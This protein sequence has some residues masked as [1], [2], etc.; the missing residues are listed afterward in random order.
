MLAGLLNLLPNIKWERL[1]HCSLIVLSPDVIYVNSRCSHVSGNHGW[2]CL[3]VLQVFVGGQA[4][5]YWFYRTLKETSMDQI[6]IDSIK[7]YHV[8]YKMLAEFGG[9]SQPWSFVGFIKKQL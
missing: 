4:N 8:A 6:F 1:E 5:L 3:N 2:N 7:F 9:K